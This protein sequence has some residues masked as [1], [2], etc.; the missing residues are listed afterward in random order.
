MTSTEREPFGRGHR[1]PVSTCPPRRRRRRP[2]R[3]FTAALLLAALVTALLVTI[4][5][6]A[7]ADGDPASDVLASSA[8]FLPVDAGVSVHEQQQMS[9][10]L[11]L[12]HRSGFSV[13]VAIVAKQDDL[14]AVAPLWR[15]PATYA[16]F[17]GIELS[18]VYRQRLLVVMPNGF[19]LDWQG[20]S[21]RA[22]DHLLSSVKIEPGG[23]GFAAATELAV[24][25][26]AAAAGVQLHAAGGDTTRNGNPLIVLYLLLVL[27]ACTL[28]VWF[29]LGGR[30]KVAGSVLARSRALW[31]SMRRLPS[32][33][34]SP[35]HPTWR[36]I[37]VALGA[38]LV[39]VAA[40]GAGAWI[41]LRDRPTEDITSL[42][43]W[44]GK[45]APNFTLTDQD[46][47]R[48]SLQSFRGKAVA[49][50]WTDPECRNVCPLV[51]QFFELVDHDLGSQARRVV[52]L[53]VDAN[54]AF[55]SPRYL[56]AFDK[57]HGLDRLHNFY[58]FTGSISQLRHVWGDYGV[59]VSFT[60]C[61]GKSSAGQPPCGTDT[62]TDTIGF[63]DPSG[64]ERALMLPWADVHRD[65]TGWLPADDVDTF[66]TS[67]K[68]E[69]QKMLR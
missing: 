53:S 22:A 56:K 52:F 65:G 18:G 20:H 27:A 58:F 31:A 26:L 29:V 6:T 33:I 15:R 62:H 5:P 49:L 43:P 57:E 21:T 13:R 30:L 38:V 10:L 41:R 42:Q 9:H 3:D 61:L 11:G 2:R 16:H 46:G 1:S 4:A 60:P 19:G 45:P 51:A 14:G 44:T 32:G 59:S 28:V 17:L 68:G 23:S 64:H 55:R 7:Y 39:C 47:R 66:V 69:L 37:A 34:R 12:A 35:R 25:R 8:L 36:W 50:Y 48:R 40:A 63:I 54:P 24:R 67:I